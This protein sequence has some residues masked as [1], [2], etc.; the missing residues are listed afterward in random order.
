[1]SSVPKYGTG[2]VNVFTPCSHV[3]A[4]GYFISFHLQQL[5]SRQLAKTSLNGLLRSA[6]TCKGHAG[7]SRVSCDIAGLV[8]PSSGHPLLL[9]GSHWSAA[10]CSTPDG[11]SGQHRCPRLEYSVYSMMHLKTP[12]LTSQRNLS[13]PDV[14]TFWDGQPSPC[15]FG[16]WGHLRIGPWGHDVAIP[17]LST[18]GHGSEFSRDRDFLPCS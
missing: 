4:R 1:M 16:G 13:G 12:T 10:P 18:N 2:V 14:Y 6:I 11:T 9:P 3:L 15:W 7:A 5:P 8:L 17:I